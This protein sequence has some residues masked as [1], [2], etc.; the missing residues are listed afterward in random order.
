MKSKKYDINHIFYGVVG[1]ATL[2]VA[3]MGATFAYY[4]ATASNNDVIKGN[5][6]TIQFDLTVAKMTNVDETS[7]GLIPMSNNMMQKAL[8]SAKGICLDDNGNAVC[9]VYK[10]TVINS[11][12]AGM[13]MDGYVSLTGG[14]GVPADYTTYTRNTQKTTMRWAQAFCSTESSGKVTACTTAGNSTV[15][16]ST[17]IALAGLGGESVKGDGLDTTEIKTA[18]NDV[19]TTATI[20]GNS[21]NVINKNYIR[22][23]DHAPTSTSYS[24]T[25]DI[26]SALV[27]NQYLAPNDKN[28]SNNTG[29]SSGTYVDAQVYYIVVWLSE[30]GHNQ[31][32]GATGAAASANNF[33][34]GN[35]KFISAQGSE[36]SATFSGHTKVAPDTQ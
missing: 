5:M 18:N 16:A 19:T 9:Q 13:F 1:I 33:F 31:T 32:V 23:S 35:V 25:D 30:N 14:S 22:V 29:T 2:M 4:T 34:Q 11:S 36:I 15:R 17:A 10:I 28:A 7:G 8:T 24:R 27:F 21:Y 6:A 3:I 26:T 20:N 12:T